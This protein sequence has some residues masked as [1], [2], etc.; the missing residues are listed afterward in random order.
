VASRIEVDR[1]E[2]GVAIIALHGE[3]ELFSAVD[4]EK[5][6]DEALAENRGIVVDL[7]RTEF[8]DSSVVAAMLRARDEAE[9]RKLRFA[10][11]IDDGT[12]WAV[13]QLLEMTGL[14]EYFPIVSTREDAVS[15]AA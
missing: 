8:L 2:E 9:R 12:G 1:S 14:T 10:L 15:G 13:R 11:V 7:T 6:L 3:H 4:V 5:R